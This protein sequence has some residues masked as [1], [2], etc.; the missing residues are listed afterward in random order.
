VVESPFGKLRFFER[1]TFAGHVRMIY[2]ALDLMRG[3]E[4]SSTACPGH[5]WWLCG[6]A[7][8]HRDH[9]PQVIGYSDPYA[10]SRGLGRTPNTEITYGTTF[11]DRRPGPT[12]IESPPG[13]LCV[14]D[15]I[16]FRYVSDMGITGPDKAQG[17]SLQP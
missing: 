12:V 16:W 3:I 14:V 8:L 15:D 13:S 5:P 17:G 2:D 10:N 4:V 11:L 6:A 7:A 1:G 9:L